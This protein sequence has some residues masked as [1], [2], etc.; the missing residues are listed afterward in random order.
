MME[1]HYR[2]QA[3]CPACGQS[4][5]C[6]TGVRDEP[7]KPGDITICFYC[8]HIGKYDADLSIIDMNE[9]ERTALLRS[10]PRVA[11]IVAQLEAS[12]E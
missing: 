3:P 2:H 7:P 6:A 8:A 12:R 9:S 4:N 11:T 10:D 5:D 1:T